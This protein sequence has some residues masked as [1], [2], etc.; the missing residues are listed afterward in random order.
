MH[1][2]WLDNYK[3]FLTLRRPSQIAFSIFGGGGGGGGQVQ[4]LLDAQEHGA[5]ASVNEF[6]ENLYVYGSGPLVERH[7]ECLLTDS[8]I[9]ERMVLPYLEVSINRLHDEE[10]WF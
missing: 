3:D 7:Q 6:C 4:R 8:A 9:I 1:K 10:P 2:P 5:V